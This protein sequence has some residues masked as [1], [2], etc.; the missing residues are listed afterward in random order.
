MSRRRD[1]HGGPRLLAGRVLRLAGVAVLLG[2]LGA[3]NP[4]AGKAP[5]L[6]S[7]GGA[8]RATAVSFHGE[9]NMFA[10]L[11][12][13]ANSPYA[14]GVL[15]SSP[16]GEASATVFDSGPLAQAGVATINQYAEQYGAPE[17][18]RA[19]QPQ[20]ATARYPGKPEEVSQTS[21]GQTD[22]S[23][24]GS[25]G[26]GSASAKAAE[27]MVQ[28]KAKA[29]GTTVAPPG[30]IPETGIPGMGS[31]PYAYGADNSEASIRI[32]ARAD[33]LF[34]ESLSSADGVD[35]AGGLMH[36][37]SVRSTAQ[38][39]NDGKDPKTYAELVAN[40]ATAGGV[41][42]VLGPNGPEVA[43][44]QIPGGADALR[45]AREQLLA[46]LDPIQMK[47]EVL[48]TEQ[49]T[50]KPK[51]PG[52]PATARVIVGGIRISWVTPVPNESVPEQTI[53]VIL[54]AAEAEGHAV[55]AVA[56]ASESSG[57][58]STEPG[59]E[60][61][62]GGV[63]TYEIPPVSGSTSSTAS[64]GSPTRPSSQVLVGNLARQSRRSG[65]LLLA[66]FALWQMAAT[67]VL[68]SALRRRQLAKA[69]RP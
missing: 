8:T 34:F 21:I 67:S 35:I 29:A 66:L 64:P 4:A 45:Q 69:W 56:Q 50:T 14:T 19:S 32:E 13:E 63:S 11:P 18:L 2:A 37:D 68:V 43:T 17:Q 26:A 53:V 47:V 36:F 15:E 46:A 23:G 33:G 58:E 22:P 25:A 62:G 40:G 61:V 24:M 54:G 44:N 6:A 7:Y 52:M 41:P 31:S 55:V 10:G 51:E 9:T 27:D 20:Y 16:A 12:E 59:P 49:T 38:I 1:G 28:A 42:V 3:A 5:Q 60:E 30:G 57:G 39:L 65:W 48:H